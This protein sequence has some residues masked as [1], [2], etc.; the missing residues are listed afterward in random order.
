MRRWTEAIDDD[1]RVGGGANVPDD[2]G[3]GLAMDDDDYDDDPNI[4]AGLGA[5]DTMASDNDNQSNPSLWTG[6][7]SRQLGNVGVPG[8][9]ML[10]TLPPSTFSARGD[11]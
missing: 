9:R 6:D 2:D 3:L 7:Q 1:G 4:H 5:Q 10:D 8:S 11:D